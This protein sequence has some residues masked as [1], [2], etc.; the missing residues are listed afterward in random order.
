M[1]TFVTALILLIT[2]GFYTC[3]TSEKVSSNTLDENRRVFWFYVSLREVKIKNTDHIAY[4]LTR[5]GSAIEKGSAKEYDYLLWK[6]LSEG[7]KFA[8]GPFND[9]EEAK[10]AFLF[11]KIQDEP[12]KLD[13]TYDQKRQIFWFVL[14]V[15]KRERSKSLELKRIPGAI[16]SGKYSVFDSFLKENLFN[17]VMTIGPFYTMPDAEE[18][19]R[20]YRLH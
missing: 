14:H 12:H 2:A 1:K 3:K 5:L 17:R 8:I 20:I 18:S 4:K 6:Y 7:T 10:Q 19:K 15:N 13:A 16:A 9:S 11:Y